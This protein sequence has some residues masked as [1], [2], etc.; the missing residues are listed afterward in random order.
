M[1]TL[2]LCSKLA[3][4]F[5]LQL[6]EPALPAARL[7]IAKPRVGTAPDLVYK[8]DIVA[9]AL[10]SIVSLVDRLYGLISV[11]GPLI[12]MFGL[13]QSAEYASDMKVDFCQTLA[14]PQRG[15]EQTYDSG[16]SSNHY[17]VGATMPRRSQQ[18]GTMSWS[19]IQD[20]IPYLQVL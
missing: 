8:A 6:L 12:D 13:P 15:Y 11:C 7:F 1:H 3:C 18:A 5:R 17:G 20:S 16:L 14:P 10:R 19:S 2:C 4:R 9:S